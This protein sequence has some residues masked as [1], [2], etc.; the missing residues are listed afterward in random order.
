[1]KIKS[2]KQLFIL[3][4]IAS[5]ITVVG[6]MIGAFAPSTNTGSNALA[7]ATVWVENIMGTNIFSRELMALNCFENLA[8]WQIGLGATIGGLG[9]LGQYLGFYGVYKTFDN[10][11]SMLAKAYWVGNIGFAF[12][13][14]IVH[15]VLCVLMYVYK[16]N[17]NSENCWKIVGEFSLWFIVPI[18]VIFYVLYAIF[19][20]AM[21]IQIFKKHTI[22]P[23]WCCALNPVIGKAFFGIIVAVLPDSAF[24]NAF[25]NAK[26]GLTSV[27]TLM[28]LFICLEKQGEFTED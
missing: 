22:F 17:A 28:C 9:I 1:M 2:I 5:L 16:M 25:N 6:E 11:D 21:F 18:T 23:R 14:S 7:D 4:L 13:G 10:K 8:V 3:G 27:V 26:M 19:S 20:V 24:T 12:I 15:V